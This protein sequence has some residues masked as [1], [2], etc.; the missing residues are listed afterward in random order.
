VKRAGQGLIRTSLGACLLLSGVQAAAE[1]KA[2][3]GD[4]TQS[5]VVDTALDNDRAAALAYQQAG[6]C[7]A[8][9]DLQCALQNMQQSYLL[10]GRAELLFNVAGLE[11]ELQ[12][13]QA[14]FRDYDGYLRSVPHGKYRGDAQRAQQELQRE[15][16]T[17][18]AATPEPAASAVRPAAEPEPRALVLPPPPTAKERETI[19]SYWTPGRVLGWTAIGA[20][21]VSGSLALYF[22]NAAI[23]DRNEVVRLAAPYKYEPDNPPWLDAQ[24]SQHR[25]QH[26]AQIL[27]ITAGAL[28]AGG[29]VLLIFAPKTESATSPSATVAAYPGYLGAVCSGKF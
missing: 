27:G 6:A 18:A 15:C 23:S 24:E 7:Y 11:R 22:L 26:A 9:G 8:S 25:N 13:C 29:A 10:S 3:T 28:V 4:A 17:A 2:P 16:P 19:G 14:A 5:L 12:H 1:D 21:A 20:G